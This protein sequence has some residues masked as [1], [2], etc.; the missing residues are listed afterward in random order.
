MEKI[1]RRQTYLERTID[2]SPFIQSG[3]NCPV[4]CVEY[5][6]KIY[7][8]FYISHGYMMSLSQCD[9]PDS[10]DHLSVQCFSF[11]DRRTTLYSS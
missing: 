7:Q 11:L 4:P 8:Y 2:V 1:Q 6:L 10:A 3:Q 5:T 9:D